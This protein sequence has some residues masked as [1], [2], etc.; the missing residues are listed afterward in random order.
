MKIKFE[1]ENG[2]III[3]IQKEKQRQPWAQPT[4]AMRNKKAYSRKNRF[5]PGE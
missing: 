4:R 1:I 5:D 2:A 3:P